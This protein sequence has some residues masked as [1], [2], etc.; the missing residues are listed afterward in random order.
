MLDFWGIEIDE[1][2]QSGLGANIS[3]TI[4]LD[5]RLTYSKA[6]QLLQMPLYGVDEVL[7]TVK[8]D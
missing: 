6:E 7:S 8:R 1:R 4:P 5:L 2:V 3:S